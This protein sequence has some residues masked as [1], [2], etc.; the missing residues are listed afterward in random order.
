MALKAVPAVNFG[1]RQAGIE[2]VSPVCGLRPTRAARSEAVNVPKPIRR[3]SSPAATVSTTISM[4]AS[5]A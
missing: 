4:K 2:I 5:T 1:V 3:T